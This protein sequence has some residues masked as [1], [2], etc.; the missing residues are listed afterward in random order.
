MRSKTDKVVAQNKRSRLRNDLSDVIDIVVDEY[1]PTYPELFN[2]ICDIL[3]S[4]SRIM[5]QDFDEK[6]IVRPKLQVCPECETELVKKRRA[7]SCPKCTK[8]SS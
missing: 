4:Y 2:A 5:M 6:R 1:N 3:Y 8:I 7:Y